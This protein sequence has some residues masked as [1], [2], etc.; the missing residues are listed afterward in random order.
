MADGLLAAGETD[1]VAEELELALAGYEDR[2]DW[3]RA[4]EMADR[5]VELTPDSVSLPSEAGRAGLPGRRSGSAAGGLSRV[6]A[7]PGEVRR[8]GQGHRGLR[9]GH[10]ARSQPCARRCCAGAAGCTCA[11][12][13]APQK[14]PSRARRPRLPACSQ[15][16]EPG[17]TAG[18]DAAQLQAAAPPRRAKGSRRLRRRPAR[19]PPKPAAPP[20]P[21]RPAAAAIGRFR[22]PRIDGVRGGEAAAI[23]G[24]G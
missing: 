24:C 7:M 12:V 19:R 15:G 11:A 18:A 14:P 4:A 6:W 23:P 17:P 21:R 8:A 3:A 16:S 10:R 1:R 22:G 20:A 2:E 13:P 5:L 9:P